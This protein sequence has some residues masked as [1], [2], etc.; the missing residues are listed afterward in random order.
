MCDFPILLVDDDP[1]IRRFIQA[2]LSKHGFQVLE[3]PDGVSALATVR[4]LDGAISLLVSDY[5]MPGLDGGILSRRLR[6]HFPAIPILLITAVREMKP[7]F[8]AAG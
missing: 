4:K 1:Q 5:S 8:R 2:V 3:V 6:D 7:S